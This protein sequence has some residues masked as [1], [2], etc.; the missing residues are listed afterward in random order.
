MEK[1][2]FFDIVVD[3]EKKNIKHMHLSVFPPDAHVHLSMPS[4]LK[5]E[6]AEAYL[7]SEWSWIEKQRKIVL[8][9]ERQ[10]KRTYISAEN[11]YY[12]GFRYRLKIVE[13]N[14]NSTIVERKRGVLILHVRKDSTEEKRAE[15]LWNWYRKELKELLSLYLV[16]W[17]DKLGETKPFSWQVRRLKT[18]WGSC[19]QSK[20]SMLFNLALARVPKEC[21]EYIVVHELIHLKCRTHNKQFESLLTQAMPDWRRRKQKLNEFIAESYPKLD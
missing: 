8:N 2:S 20:R 21:V 18:E 5:K 10:T 7:Y 9:Q 6:D 3:V 14:I 17:T 4:Y 16:K 11:H 12:F 1:I 19:V 13:A 15:I